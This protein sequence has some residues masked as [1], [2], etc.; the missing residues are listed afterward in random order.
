MVASTAIEIPPPRPS[1]SKSRFA[2][3]RDLPDQDHIGSFQGAIMS[4]S[5]GM[6]GLG[7]GGV[8]VIRDRAAK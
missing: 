5:H 3:G 8:S 2:V 6:W 4:G 1:F 7:I